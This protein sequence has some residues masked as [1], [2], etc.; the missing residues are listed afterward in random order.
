MH[1][2][3]IALGFL[4]VLP[5]RSEGI[6][7]EE[8]GRALRFFP[9]VGLVL[10]LVIAGVGE[11]ALTYLPSAVAAVGLVA[12]LAMLT[13]GL[14]LDGAADLFD[15]LGSGSGDR[16]RMLEIMRDSRIGAHGAA[17]VTLLLLA[18][19][20][21]LTQILE[22]RDVAALVVFPAV[23]RWAVVPLIMFFPPAR[24]DGLGA[25]FKR[26]ASLTDLAVASVFAGVIVI[27]CGR[28]LLA[29]VA[30]LSG[31]AAL[32][33]FVQ[34]RLGGFT[35]DVCGAAIEIAEVICL[36]VLVAVPK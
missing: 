5:M 7:E 10:G 2:L 24:Q 11:V 15:A 26:H 1:S 6:G 30:A 32:G 34:S 20:S 16:R 12:L 14:H 31:S 25:V 22:H 36:V 3:A 35:G 29:E 23:A 28:F 17:A 21:A 8:V 13:G 9:A 27:A 18:K 4:T 19:A 33:L